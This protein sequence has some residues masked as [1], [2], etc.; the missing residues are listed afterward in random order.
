[1]IAWCFALVFLT[2]CLVYANSL[3]NG[4]TLD[5]KAIVQ[6]NEKIRSLDQIPLIWAS[7]YWPH[8]RYI[9]NYRP[10]TVTTYALNHA[11]HGLRPF[12]YHLVNVL[13]HASVSALLVLL[14]LR[15]GVPLIGALMA[16]LF[17][18]VHPIH[19]DVV[20]GVVGR[21]E[22]LAALAFI[23]G[24]FFWLRYRESGQN[25]YLSALIAVFVL[26]NVSKEQVIVMP[27]LFVIAEL[28]LHRLRDPV[29]LRR[30][31]FALVGCGV[32]L[33]LIFI[34]REAATGSVLAGT[35]MD[36]PVTTGLLY[37]EPVRVRVLTFL[38]VLPKIAGLFLFPIGLSPDYTYNQIPIPHEIDRGVLAG[39]CVALLCGVGLVRARKA[40]ARFLMGAWAFLIYLPVSNLLVPL[41]LL[42]AE[43][44]LYVPSIGLAI[45]AGDW[46]ASGTRW[47]MRSARLVLFTLAGAAI[48]L[49]GVLTVARNPVWRNQMTLFAAGVESAPNSAFL[50]MSYGIELLNQ[51]RA[52]EA[53]RQLELG[54][55][56]HPELAAAHLNLSVAYQRLNKPVKAEEAI[57]A[58]LHFR[59]DHP[60]PWVQLGRVLV[61]QGR[62]GDAERALRRGL[63]LNPGSQAIRNLLGEIRT[64]R[65][66]SVP[67]EP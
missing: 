46:L 36:H 67:S 50:R 39:A 59:L 9:K 16:G 62:T 17:F 41:P 53:A 66:T 23:G 57:R 1:M 55:A 27:A 43:R 54:V 13:L 7:S 60:T 44:I 26:G 58:L 33:A 56:I 32:M 29:G 24:L 49:W 34:L 65:R 35:L 12:G 30:L 31:T 10:L 4:F 64:S 22:L 11:V 52:E 14:S 8:H 18:A 37:G 28:T 38:K 2:S 20:S 19:T 15:I 5:D 25:R 47:P 61:M 51:G 6:H 21:A 48:L 63:A 42:F 40:Q 45:I 3:S